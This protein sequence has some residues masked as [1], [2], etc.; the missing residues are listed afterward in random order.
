MSIAKEKALLSLGWLNAKYALGALELGYATW[1][2][3]LSDRC[4]GCGKDE[5]L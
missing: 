1:T 4:M 2:V 3:P 5:K